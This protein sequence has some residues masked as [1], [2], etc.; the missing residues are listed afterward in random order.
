MTFELN[1]NIRNHARAQRQAEQQ[2]FNINIDAQVC[3]CKDFQGVTSHFELF[4]VR[5]LCSHLYYVIWYNDLLKN[6]SDCLDNFV[7]QKIRR[8][9]WGVYFFEDEDNGRFAIIAYRDQVALNVTIP[10]NNGEGYVMSRWQFEDGAWLGS[11]G[12][13]RFQQIVRTK[14][15]S[16]FGGAR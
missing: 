15:E 9:V 1:K 3:N 16:L 14:L 8:D 10:K 7:L 5:R 11:G 4:D 13:K 12:S 6:K 2:Y